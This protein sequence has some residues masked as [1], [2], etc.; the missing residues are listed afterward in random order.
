MLK[1]KKEEEYFQ[2]KLTRGKKQE[3]ARKREEK[4]GIAICLYP[5][6]HRHIRAD[7]SKFLEPK[8]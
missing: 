3:K 6:M 1:R 5:K 2:K 7:P 4:R 8:Y